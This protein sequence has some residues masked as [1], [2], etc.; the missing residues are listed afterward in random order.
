MKIKRFL[1]SLPEKTDMKIKFFP[2]NVFICSVILGP[3]YSL[4]TCQ[5]QFTG[6]SDKVEICAMRDSDANLK[7]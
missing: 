2:P 7:L 1:F 4:S 5:P 3:S 6:G